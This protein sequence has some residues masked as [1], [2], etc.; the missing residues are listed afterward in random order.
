MTN[1][2][3]FGEFGT[4]CARVAVMRSVIPCPGHTDDRTPCVGGLRM[5]L[6]V[7][8]A[9]IGHRCAAVSPLSVSY[10]GGLPGHLRRNP[11]RKLVIAP[12]EAPSRVSRLLSCPR[13]AFAPPAYVLLMLGCG[14]PPNEAPPSP[15]PPAST[16]TAPL[17]AFTPA[18]AERVAPDT[19]VRS[20]ASA[21]PPPTAATTSSSP[22][23][24]G[25]SKWQVW[26]FV[27]QH[28]DEVRH[29]FDGEWKKLERNA[30]VSIRLTW[31][32]QPSG[33]VKGA[34][35][36]DKHDSSARADACVVAKI[37]RWTFPTSA[38]PTTV[39]DYRFEFSNDP[40][41]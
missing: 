16:T 6:R 23:Q 29:C 25:L 32:V 17:P 12:R 31:V 19:S 27:G 9:T 34:R 3:H 5:A 10:E 30:K 18:P 1:T 33:D 14:S 28:L 2:C 8:I 7:S 20:A 41:Y 39:D 36:V 37:G 40:G 26:S 38:T 24:G 22:Q 15:P 4:R 21:A 11:R 35:V 13:N